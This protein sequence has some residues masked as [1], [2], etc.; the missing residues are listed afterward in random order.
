M[1][2]GIFSVWWYVR[3][4]DVIRVFLSVMVCQRN[5][6]PSGCFSVVCQSLRRHQGVSDYGGIS[7]IVT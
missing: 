1:S 3:A 6:T 2:S 5:V 7:E 4:C